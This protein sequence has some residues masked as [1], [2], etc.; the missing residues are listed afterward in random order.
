MTAGSKEEHTAESPSRD[1]QEYPIVGQAIIE[2]ILEAGA[3]FGQ[4]AVGVGTKVVVEHTNINSNKAADLDHLRNSCI[5]DTVV[6]MLRSQGYQ[7]EAHHSIDDTGVQVADVVAGFILLNEGILQLPGGDAQ[8]PGETFDYYCSRVHNAVGRAYDSL[9]VLLELRKVVLRAIEHGGKPLTGPDYP[10]LAAGI[11]HRIVQ[12]H[13]ATMARLNISYDLL[14]WGS[15]ILHTGLWKRTFEMLH[16]RGVLEKPETGK[17]AGCWILPFGEGAVQTNEGDHTSDKILMRRDCT[18][19]YTARDIAHQH[20]GRMLWAMRAREDSVSTKEEAD[21]KRFGHA[22]GAINVIDVR[23]AFLQ[24]LI[25]ESLRQLGYTSQADDSVCLIHEV[26]TLS[27]ATAVHL[28][29]ATSNRRESYTMSGR[30]GIEIKAD[31]LI[32]AAI[33][34]LQETKPELSY[35]T[36]AILAAS[37]IRYFMLRSNLQQIIDLDMDEALQANVDTGVY[38]QYVYAAANSILRDLE[39]AGYETLEL[40]EAQPQ[41]LEQSEWELLRHLDAYPHMLRE[42]TVELAPHLFAAYVYDLATHFSNFCKHTPPI[43][44]ETDERVKAFRVRLVRAATQTM[45]N[46]LRVLGFVPLERI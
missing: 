43:V 35:E 39:E 32:N 41:Q 27:A 20:D 2:R 31:D 8:L 4:S 21:P 42:A 34:R 38:L 30:K 7:V 17:M 40:L 22:K 25:Y 45:D 15:A 10:T 33:A 26:V 36:A 14:I 13:L 23:Q 3:D 18:T 24:Q 19:T 46:A 37:A 11:S 28:R 1:T 9:P 5:G 29:V 44:K 12:A 16:E 6:R